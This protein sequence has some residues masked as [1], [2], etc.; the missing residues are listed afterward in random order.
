MD[1]LDGLPGPPGPK[2]EPGQQQD[3]NILRLTPVFFVVF[4]FKLKQMMVLYLK[5][6]VL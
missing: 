6:I 1:G 4:F 2:G 3:I 5:K